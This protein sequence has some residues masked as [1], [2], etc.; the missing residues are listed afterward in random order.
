MS[1]KSCL[2]DFHKGYHTEIVHNAY[3]KAQSIPR[4]ELLQKNK[5]RSN[6]QNQAYCVTKYSSLANPIK[7]IIHS[8]CNLFKSDTVLRK[9]FY[10]PP[11]ICFKRAP[12]L[13]DRLVPSHLPAKKQ[14]TW[15][16]RQLKGTYKCGSCNHC[17]NIKEYKSCD[18]KTNK[19]YNIKA[20][21]NCNTTFVVHRLS[22]KCGCFLCKPDLFF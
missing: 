13:R 2:T 9:V 8:N 15:L 4:S 20:F 21:I 17:S 11:K 14:M 3:R 7:R 22:C 10:A 18:F 6:K 16:H 5:K 19:M 1:F 12:T